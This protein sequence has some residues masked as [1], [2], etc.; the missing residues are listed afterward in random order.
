MMKNQ[1]LGGTEYVLSTSGEYLARIR[2]NAITQ[3][4]ES[5]SWFMMIRYVSWWDDTL[6]D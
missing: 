3:L 6:D 2:Q 1:F 4:F 5:T